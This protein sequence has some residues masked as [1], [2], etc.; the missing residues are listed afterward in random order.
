MATAIK[1]PELRFPPVNLWSAPR[2]QQQLP[3]V[4]YEQARSPGMSQNR[5]LT[6]RHVRGGIQ[7]TPAGR[8][9]PLW[10]GASR[11]FREKTMNATSLFVWPLADNVSACVSAGKPRSVNAVEDGIP[12]V[13]AV[14]LAAHNGQAVIADFD[15]GQTGAIRWLKASGLLADPA[16][17]RTARLMGLVDPAGASFERS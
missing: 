10:G 15:G 17:E 12:P 14:L 5:H 7:P 3:P 13:L 1:W 2:N 9:S 6:R 4:R 8:N 11:G 16:V